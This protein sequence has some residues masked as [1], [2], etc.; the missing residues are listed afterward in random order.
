MHNV[1]V[2]DYSTNST[3]KINQPFFRD[4][5]FE[6]QEY[7]LDTPYQAVFYEFITSYFSNGLS[8]IPSG[9]VDFCFITDTSEPCLEIIGSPTEYKSV[10]RIPNAHYF[11]VRLKP[12]MYLNTFGSSLRDMVNAECFLPCNN[13]AVKVF[14]ALLKKCNTF[15]QRIDCFL[16]CFSPEIEHGSS[17]EIS[18][19][20]LSS[21][22]ASK[23]N[24]HINNLAEEMNYSERHISRMFQDTMGMTPKTF[25]RIVRF[26]HAVDAII[27]SHRHPISDYITDL[28][29]SDQAH[30]QR[31]F[32]Q[33]AGITPKSFIQYLSHS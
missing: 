8:C 11:G 6:Y 4:G 7:K 22:N 15:E 30:F 18:Q 21:I 33:Y 20:M 3:F 26:Q 32:K 27:F 5:V 29:Y 28:G 9:G 25:S 2:H 16:S 12:G 19:Y 31:E 24:L 23:G 13:A 17:G 10:K 14:F 1:M